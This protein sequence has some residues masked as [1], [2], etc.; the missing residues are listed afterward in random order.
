MENVLRL[1]EY[2]KSKFLHIRANRTIIFVKR[3]LNILSPFC[4]MIS[5]FLY[6]LTLQS[7]CKG[8]NVTQANCLIGLDSSFLRANK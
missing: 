1:I 5:I 7:A 3:F 8:T 2:N 6:Y 4:I